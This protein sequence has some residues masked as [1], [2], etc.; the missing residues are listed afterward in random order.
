MGGISL[1]Q[2]F[3]IQSCSLTIITVKLKCLELTNHDPF[4]KLMILY[5]ADI[6][7]SFNF[8]RNNLT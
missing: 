6:I 2:V 1:K 3:Y 4:L 7:Y 5:E 8:R